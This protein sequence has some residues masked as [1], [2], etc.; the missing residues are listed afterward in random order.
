MSEYVLNYTGDDG[1]SYFTGK[2]SHYGPV[3]SGDKSDSKSFDNDEDLFSTMQDL[4]SDSF[5]PLKVEIL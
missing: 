2:L 4:I 1:D 3:W 5:L